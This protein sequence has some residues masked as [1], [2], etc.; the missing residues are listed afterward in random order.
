[1][2]RGGGDDVDMTSERDLGTVA[3]GPSN[4][5]ERTPR[6]IFVCG[7]SGKGAELKFYRGETQIEF[8]GRAVG[9]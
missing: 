3:G 9:F 4:A 5:N 7:A 2:G 6:M 8:A 1:M